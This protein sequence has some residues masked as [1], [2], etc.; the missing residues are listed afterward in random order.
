VPG[1]KKSAKAKT[2]KVKSYKTKK[3]KHVT[4]HY[5][6]KPGKRHSFILP[7]IDFKRREP[8]RHKRNVLRFV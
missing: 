2:V 4:A 5:R 6:S 3:G 8:F 7:V 1:H